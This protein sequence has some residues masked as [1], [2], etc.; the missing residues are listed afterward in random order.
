MAPISRSNDNKIVWMRKSNKKKYVPLVS[1]VKFY[2]PLKT[3]YNERWY[4]EEKYFHM[5][6]EVQ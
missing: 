6:L 5:R 1:A 2:V 4:I 3:V